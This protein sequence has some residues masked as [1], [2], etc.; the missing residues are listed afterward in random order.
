[1]GFIDLFVLSSI[2]KLSKLVLISTNPLPATVSEVCLADW[3]FITEH[4][5]QFIAT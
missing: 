1:M 2:A 5:F 4:H 3:R